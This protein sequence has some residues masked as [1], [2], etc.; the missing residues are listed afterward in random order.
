MKL[1]YKFGALPAALTDQPEGE[2][3]G[4]PGLVEQIAGDRS[5]IGAALGGGVGWSGGTQGEGGWV[6]VLARGGCAGE[7]LWGLWRA[8]RVL[9]WWFWRIAGWVRQ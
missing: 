7:W 9:A 4:R 2:R 3:P 1:P 8:V 6:L 5:V